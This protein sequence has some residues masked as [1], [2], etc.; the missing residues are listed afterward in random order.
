MQANGWF[1]KR[2]PHYTG[3]VPVPAWD[4]RNHWQG[5]V[6]VSLLPRSY[7]PVEGFI[8]SANENINPPHGPLLI[9][10]PVSD[11]RKRRILKRLADLRVRAAD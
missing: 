1:P 6:D 11:Y 7:D 3:L 8:A 9:S 5:L 4:E 2:P 10:M